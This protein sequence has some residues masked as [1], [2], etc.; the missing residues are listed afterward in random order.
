MKNSVAKHLI[1]HLNL[2]FMRKFPR[3]R[4]EIRFWCSFYYLLFT[5]FNTIHYQTSR[6]L[7]HQIRDFI[8]EFIVAVDVSLQHNTHLKLLLSSTLVRIYL[9]LKFGI[10]AKVFQ[11]PLTICQT[12]GLHELVFQELA[13]R[14]LPLIHNKTPVVCIPS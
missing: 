12:V 8:A 7:G 10:S 13:Y 6:D 9:F 4:K 14:N 5:F 1:N 3:N 11:N 2:C